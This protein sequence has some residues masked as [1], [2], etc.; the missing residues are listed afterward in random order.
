MRE[1]GGVQ[2]AQGF[3]IGIIT[4]GDFTIYKKNGTSAG[5]TTAFLWDKENNIG[6]SVA[7]NVIPFSEGINGFICD[8][9]YLIYLD[10]TGKVLPDD[11]Y[12]ACRI[13][14]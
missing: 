7:G 6:L 14:F 1:S 13:P 12:E 5:T 2:I 3:G 10:H 8:I 4:E 11:V 9:Y